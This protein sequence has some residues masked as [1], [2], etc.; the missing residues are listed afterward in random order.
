MESGVQ[1][2][3]RQFI[4]D[5]FPLARKQQIKDSDPLLESGMVDSMGVLDV[6][7]FLEQEYSIVV[8]DEDLIPE[9]F[10][11]IARIAAFVQGRVQRNGVGCA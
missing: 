6:V 3:I 2:G 1:T 8:E 10:Q 11:T 5:K 9:N 4:L 7:G